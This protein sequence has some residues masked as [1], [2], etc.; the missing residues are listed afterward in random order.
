MTQKDLE[1]IT[2]LTRRGVEYNLQKLKKEGV[3]KRIGGRKEGY[4]EV[5]K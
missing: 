5:I 1:E 2:N 3:L 4:L